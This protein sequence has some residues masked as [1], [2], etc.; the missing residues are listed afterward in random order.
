MAGT[1][2]ELVR[3]L[4]VAFTGAELQKLKLHSGFSSMFHRCDG[5]PASVRELVQ[6]GGAILGEEDR[7]KSKLSP[8]R[9]RNA[10]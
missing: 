8:L 6:M 2:S 3:K 10:A 7:Q 4:R 5:S 1:R 9:R